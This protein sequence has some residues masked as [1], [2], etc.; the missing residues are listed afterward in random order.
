MDQSLFNRPGVANSAF[1]IDNLHTDVMAIK[2]PAAQNIPMAL[3]QTVANL[4]DKYAAPIENPPAGNPAEGDNKPVITE[5]FKEGDPAVDAEVQNILEKYKAPPTGT[6]P[7]AD[8][9][10]AAAPEPN[11]AGDP[12]EEPPAGDVVADFSDIAGIANMMQEKGLIREVPEGI[13]PENLTLESFWEVVNH[14][15]NKE[16]EEEYVAGHQQA[17]ADLVGKIPP[18]MREALQYTLNNPNSSDDEALAYVEALGFARSISTLDAANVVD[19]EQIIRQYYATTGEYSKEEIN[20]LIE[21]ERTAQRLESRAQLLKPKLELRLKQQKE[22][23]LEEIRQNQLQQEA[24]EDQMLGRVETILKSG[25]INGIPVTQDEIRLLWAVFSNNTV[26][27]PVKGGRTVEMGFLDHL[28]RKHRFS[29]EGSLE[30]LMLATLVMEGKDD[31]VKRFYANPVAKEEVKKFVNSAKN[32]FKAAGQ[33]PAPVQ[34]TRTNSPT[35]IP[36][37]DKVQAFF[38]QTRK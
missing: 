38:K 25:K 27:V 18:V 20:L 1:K 37:T 23:K 30:R 29:Q 33:A 34:P 32:Q 11:P 24:I 7:A 13:D 5:P 14:N 6:P 12:T 2:A 22:R 3:D 35:S 19:A 17:I 8:P 9:A 21:D 31:V 16:R 28:T 4:T 10:K 36:S 26:P 15:L